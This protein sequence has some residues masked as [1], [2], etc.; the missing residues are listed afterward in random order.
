[1]AVKDFQ[2]QVKLFSLCANRQYYYCLFP[3]S[4]LFS[5]IASDRAC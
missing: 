2:L 4:Y 5:L 1:M 3:R